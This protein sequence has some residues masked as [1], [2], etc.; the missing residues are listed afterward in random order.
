VSKKDKHSTTIGYSTSYTSKVNKNY[1]RSWDWEDDYYDSYYGGKSSKKSYSGGS[2]YGSSWSW[3]NFGSWGDDWSEDKDNDL[4]IKGSD[5]YFTPKSADISNKLSMNWKLDTKDNRT[6]IKEMSRFFYHRMLEDKDYFDEKFKDETKLSDENIALL[7]MKKMFYEELWDK[8]IPGYTPLEKAINVLS[9]IA[10]KSPTPDKVSMQQAVEE[11]SGIQYNED[12]YNDPVFNEL[13]DANIFSQKH[14]FAI[15]NKISMV[16]NLG[17]EFKVEKEIEEK[18]VSNSRIVAK[19]IIRDYSEIANVEL[20]ERLMPNFNI[21]LLNKDLVVNVPVDRTEHKQKIIILLD[22]SGS[23]CDNSK[24]IWVAAILIDR[25][26]YAIKEEAE[27]FF[28]YFNYEENHMRFTHIYNRETA[29]KFWATFSSSPNGGDTRLGNMVNRINNE[30]NNSKRLMNLDVDLSE[31][32]PEI[33]AIND[34]NDS[35]KTNKFEYKTNAISL[36]SGVN[37][38]LR[39]LCLKNKGKYITV[40]RQE[41]VTAHTESGDIRIKA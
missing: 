41:N 2:S 8:Y 16:K 20:A 25:M 9:E 11:I 14:K 17:S 33:L 7:G 19:K 32:K 38:E 29:M 5:S 40:D 13:M 15:L 23:M 18:R 10:K 3:G 39:D 4:F 35:V 24:Q 37:Q 36:M 27:I 12:V 26:K 31:D 21:K 28:S 30:I 1:S 22:Y 34:G 6:L